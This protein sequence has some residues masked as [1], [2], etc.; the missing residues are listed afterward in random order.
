MH[1]LWCALLASAG[2]L[3][4]NGC[5]ADLKSDEAKGKDNDEGVPVE[6]FSL[7]QGPIESVF[8]T[9]TDLEAEEEV[10]VFAR[11]SN[12]VAEL[13]V[14]EGDLV[15]RDQLLLRLED[16]T[17]KTQVAKAATKL[18]KAKQEFQR[19]KSLFEQRLISEQ[20]FN[21]AEFELKQLELALEDAQRELEFTQIKAPISGTIARRLIKLGDQVN[22]QQHL[23][24]VVDFGSIVARVYVPEKDL[25][26]LT[27]NQPARV[28]TSA[29]GNHQH[30]G[31]IKRI[32]PIVDAKTG[33]VK[34]TIG[35]EDVQQLRP[36]MYVKVVIVLAT[37]TDALLIPKRAIGYDNDQQMYVFR[38]KS[39]RR[40][41]R[42]SFQPLISDK[43]NVQPASGFSPGDQIVVA[44]QAGLKDGS[45]IRLPGDPTPEKMNTAKTAKPGS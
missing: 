25:A 24:D 31:Y 20:V 44:G 2:I 33:T 5:S 9:S 12:R 14:E 23:F 27:L 42:V 40:V 43:D 18:L 1:I 26:Q 35:F 30:P 32:A 11:T 41:E 34:V 21:D 39:D 45:R 7:V 36:G 8:D 29:F 16:D 3:L 15:A 13:K 28:F 38:V 22:L 37:H 6:V 4:L 19:Q 17:Q 10:K